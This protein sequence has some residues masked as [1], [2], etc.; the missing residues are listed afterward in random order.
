[1]AAVRRAGCALARID[2]WDF[3]LELRS[4]GSVGWLDGQLL[5]RRGRSEEFRRNFLDALADIWAA[6]FTRH[7]HRSSCREQEGVAEVAASNDLPEV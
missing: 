4:L 1:M 6:R 2:D 7:F 3:G 5:Y